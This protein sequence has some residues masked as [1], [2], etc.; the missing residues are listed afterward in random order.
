VQ[1]L[2]KYLIQLE[3]KSRREKRVWLNSEGIRL[4]RLAVQR[5]TAGGV[6]SGSGSRIGEV[7]EEGDAFRKVNQRLREI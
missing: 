3:E 2:H 5:A 1:A 4:G 7:W 6:N